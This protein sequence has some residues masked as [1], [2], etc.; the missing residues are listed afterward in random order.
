MDNEKTIKLLQNIY[1]SGDVCMSE[2]LDFILTNPSDEYNSLASTLSDEELNGLLEWSG[3]S[4]WM[5][6]RNGKIVPAYDV[7]FL[8]AKD[9]RELRNLIDKYTEENPGNF[10]FGWD[11]D[12][13]IEDA[14]SNDN[15]FWIGIFRGHHLLG[16]CTIGPNDGYDTEDPEEQANGILSDVYVIPEERHTGIATEMVSRALRLPQ[17]QLLY[18]DRTIHAYLLDERLKSLYSAC[19]FQNTE[20]PLDGWHMICKL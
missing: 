1:L 7:R 20:N 5:T 2:M 15:D 3:D 8:N 11:F 9:D 10:Q 19:G 17:I 18:Q 16:I 14:T 4:Q 12:T 6:C 13:M